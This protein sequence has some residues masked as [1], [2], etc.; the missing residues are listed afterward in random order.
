VWTAKA[1]TLDFR[2]SKWSSAAAQAHGE[3]FVYKQAV[4][5]QGHAAL[6][7]EAVFNEGTDEQFWLST[8]VRIVSNAAEAGGK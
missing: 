6:L 3:S 5:D 2:A 1:A 7:G 8:N 4:P